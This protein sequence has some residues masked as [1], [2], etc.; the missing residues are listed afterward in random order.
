MFPSSSSS[1]P[2]SGVA[3]EL[4]G[5]LLSSYDSPLRVGFTTAEFARSLLS[6]GD[7]F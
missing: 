2:N 7:P 4:V 1:L 3:V 6:S 5:S